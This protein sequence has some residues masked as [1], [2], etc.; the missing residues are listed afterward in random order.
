MHVAFILAQSAT[1]FAFIVFPEG[2]DT[3]AEFVEI[4]MTACLA[5][6]SDSTGLEQIIEQEPEIYC[7]LYMIINYVIRYTVGAKRVETKTK[8][9]G[10]AFF[11]RY[12]E[13]LPKKLK[14]G[15]TDFFKAQLAIADK[16]NLV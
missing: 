15:I 4:C 6:F 3:I 5:S 1:D 11:V 7:E 10:A 8:P 2:C 12:K 13:Y 16:G 14:R 9:R